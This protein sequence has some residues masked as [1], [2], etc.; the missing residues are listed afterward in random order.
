AQ[1]HFKGVQFDWMD[2]HRDGQ[3]FPVPN[4]RDVQANPPQEIVINSPAGGERQLTTLGLRPTGVQWSKDGSTLL[5]TA[6]SLYRNERSYGRSEI[7]TVT[8]E[9]KLSRRTP[10]T[11]YGYQGATYSPDGKWIMATRDYSSDMV[12][13]RH[14]DHGGPVDI[15]V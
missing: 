9:G 7:W 10:S 1:E 8:V 2:F 14:L 15:I 5:F 6:D 11:D 12:I 4:R 13:A 3:P